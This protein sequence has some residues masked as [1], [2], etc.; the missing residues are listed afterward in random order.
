MVLFVIQVCSD[1][2]GFSLNSSLWY[3]RGQHRIRLQ[4][5]GRYL[6]IIIERSNHHHLGQTKKGCNPARQ[7]QIDKSIKFSGQDSRTNNRHTNRS[8]PKRIQQYTRWTIWIQNRAQHKR[9][10]P[11]TNTLHTVTTF[12]DIQQASDNVPDGYGHLIANYLKNR[13]FQDYH[14]SKAR[15]IE[16]GVAQGFV[17]SPLLYDKCL[18]SLYAD[19]TK[20]IDIKTA[21]QVMQETLDK[22]TQWS[23]KWKLKI[24]GEKF[25]A[26]VFTKR[27]PRLNKTLQVQGQHIPYSTRVRYLGVLLDVD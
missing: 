5:V 19:D 2:F 9:S 24:N 13:S 26:V 22:I 11:Q 23:S 1:I 14:L 4:P 27:Y 8:N 17:S 25:N 18:H 6:P 16:A 3:N 15:N 7:L 10:T 20:H 21:C 12:L